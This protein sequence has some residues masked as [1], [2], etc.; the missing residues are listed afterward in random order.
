MMSHLG[1]NIMGEKALLGQK[2]DNVQCHRKYVC[3][4][5]PGVLK[6]SISTF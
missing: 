3:N 2:G 5:E 4:S 6:V 1:L